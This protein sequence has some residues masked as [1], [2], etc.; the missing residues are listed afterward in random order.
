MRCTAEQNANSRIHAGAISFYFYTTATHRIPTQL[1]CI[2]RENPRQMRSLRNGFPPSCT[3]S[4]HELVD[5]LHSID[6]MGDKVA[7]F[8]L[9]QKSKGVKP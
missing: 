3:K 9:T 5:A 4:G 8:L 2:L 6:F 7:S 1:S